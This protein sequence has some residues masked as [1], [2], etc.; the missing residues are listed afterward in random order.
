MLLR[1]RVQ[2]LFLDYKTHSEV[3]GGYFIKMV[4]EVLNNVVG[5]SGWCEVGPECAACG[6]CALASLFPADPQLPLK[7]VESEHLN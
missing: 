3:K 2:V 1:A 4:T 7:F 5:S 6:G